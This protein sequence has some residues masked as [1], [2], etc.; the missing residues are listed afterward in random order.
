MDQ[1]LASG[2]TPK[3]TLL[4]KDSHVTWWTIPSLL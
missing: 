2:Y 3:T 1:F 4:A